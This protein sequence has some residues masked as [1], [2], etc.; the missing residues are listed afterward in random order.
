MQI[1]MHAVQTSDVEEA[2]SRR[3]AQIEEQEK[4]V[5]G[6]AGVSHKHEGDAVSTSTKTVTEAAVQR[7]I[8]DA[9]AVREEAEK[10]SVS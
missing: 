3:R 8:S 6:A 1:L 10:A 4:A 7:A 5:A 2:A 9:A